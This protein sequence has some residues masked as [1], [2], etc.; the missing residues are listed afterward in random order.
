MAFISIRY[1]RVLVEKSACNPKFLPGKTNGRIT[2]GPPEEHNL[3]HRPTCYF[4]GPRRINIPLLQADQIDICVNTQ[5]KQP[6]RCIHL[7]RGPWV[8]CM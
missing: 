6:L 1:E 7:L 4:Y 8:L 5:Q 3:L 2:A